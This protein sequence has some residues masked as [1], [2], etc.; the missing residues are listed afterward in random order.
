MVKLIV[1]GSA[2]A[3]NA[4]GRGHS[5]YWLEGMA[6]DPLMVDFGAT[7]LLALRRCELE[8]RR[9]RTVLITHLH[10]DHLAGLPFLII[11]GMFNQLRT[12]PLRL[13]GPPG[14][15]ERVE[16]L[17]RLCYASAAEAEKPFQVKLAEVEPG[18]Q[19]QLEEARV[20]ALRAE[21]GS[22][23]DQALGYTLQSEAG[24]RVV[25]SGDTALTD[26]LLAAADGADLLVAECSALEDPGGGHCSWAQ[27][28][29][30]LPEL[31]VGRVLLSHLHAEVR[32]E[33][34]RSMPPRG[35]R[36][37]LAED[38]MAVELPPA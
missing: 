29:R 10:G 18:Q 21:H 28:R 19:V 12:L 2:D 34:P 13:V 5:C 15:G 23:P 27:W 20:Q 9:L 11:D 24:P 25:F 7:A 36:V 4:A 1:T 32:A 26:E 33:A 22:G 37:H 31:S 38:G 3:F 6:R 35:P 8:P 17:L 16:S 14:T 30:V